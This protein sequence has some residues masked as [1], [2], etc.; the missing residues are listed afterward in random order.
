[1]AK[2]L[3]IIIL[4]FCDK[5]T[6][7][8]FCGS[9]DN[10]N[11]VFSF[12][13]QS[14]HGLSLAVS[15]FEAMVARFNA[16]GLRD[17]THG[18]ALS[19]SKAQS[20]SFKGS[21]V[22]LLFSLNNLLYFELSLQLDRTGLQEPRLTVGLREV[23]QETAGLK[24]PLPATVRKAFLL[25]DPLVENGLCA[26]FAAFVEAMVVRQ[27]SFSALD[28]LTDSG[29]CLPVRASYT[30]NLPRYAA[31]R[32]LSSLGQRRRRNR[33]L[34]GSA[35]RSEFLTQL[36]RSE[37]ELAALF[38][39]VDEMSDQINQLVEH[40]TAI[41]RTGSRNDDVARVE[42]SLIQK[43]V[44]RHEATK[45]QMKLQMDVSNRLIA[46]FSQKM[47]EQ[48]A[49]ERA[50]DAAFLE[51][52]VRSLSDNTFLSLFGDTDAR[53]EPAS[54]R[55]SV[56]SELLSDFVQRDVAFPTARSLK[57]DLE[58]GKRRTALPTA[59]EPPAKESLDEYTRRTIRETLEEQ[60]QR[61][62]G[63]AQVPSVE[64]VA[65]AVSRGEL[66]A[67]DVAADSFVRAFRKES[68]EELGSQLESMERPL[69]SNGK[70]AIVRGGMP[71]VEPRFDGGLQF[72]GNGEAGPLGDDDWF[73]EEAAR[74]AFVEKVNDVQA[75]QDEL[76]TAEHQPCDR[77]FEK[78]PLFLWDHHLLKGPQVIRPVSALIEMSRERRVSLADDLK[79]KV[80]YD[81]R[82][83]GLLEDRLREGFDGTVVKRINLLNEKL[84]QTRR[85]LK[86]LQ[87]WIINVVAAVEGSAELKALKPHIRV[88]S[89]Y[90][91]YFKFER[92]GRAES[93]ARLAAFLPNEEQSELEVAV[94]MTGTAERHLLLSK[95]TR[96]S[97][98]SRE[99]TAEGQKELEKLVAEVHELSGF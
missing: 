47:R 41:K 50:D 36:L 76:R 35:V 22:R 24:N 15:F 68:L 64:E 8:C 37:L 51:K 48:S 74:T 62:S 21:E 44:S 26:L 32:T 95:T 78:A 39:E 79:L 25:T 90:S 23:I 52:V 77:V 14:S 53:R 59:A 63:K 45:A 16:F 70:T 4:L 38:N 11:R 89:D 5:V 49:G 43:V 54:E 1:M 3:I 31:S 72:E 19:L 85:K 20:L 86:E 58:E 7:N 28:R 98:G 55:R 46:D 34:L 40:V 12:S 57:W 82:V 71:D 75:T 30:Y 99:R 9:Q 73:G 13:Q 6:A 33:V 27:F 67:V 92:L 88:F 69:N 18:V 10:E 17:P 96:V 66:E 83:E 93:L 87:N 56:A 91:V 65:E 80:I 97:L 2:L 42:E 81:S 94:E 29:R 61:L 60:R 84:P